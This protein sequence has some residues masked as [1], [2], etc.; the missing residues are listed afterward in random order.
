MARDH[1][2]GLSG[3][4]IFMARLEVE[5]LRPSMEDGDETKFHLH[6]LGCKCRVCMHQ[7]QRNEN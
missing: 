2:D 6:S 4:E 7:R 5:E 1:L 3:N